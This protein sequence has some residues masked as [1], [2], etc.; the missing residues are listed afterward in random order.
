MPSNN[1]R[2]RTPEAVIP[3]YWD[4]TGNIF[5]P[6]TAATPLPVS[7]TPGTP[8][9]LATRTIGRLTATTTSGAT[10]FV[11]ALAGRQSLV[12]TNGGAVAV[13]IGPSGVTAANGHLLPAGQ[14]IAFEANALNDG[15]APLAYFVITAASTADCS[16]LG[17]S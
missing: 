12:I 1:Y 4:V 10:A 11:P 14:S 7:F 17:L 9:A 6:A 3:G 5:V 15:G 13:S 2:G 16:Y 8:T